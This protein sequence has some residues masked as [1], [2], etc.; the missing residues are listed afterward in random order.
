MKTTPWF[1]AVACLSALGVAH[2]QDA[3]APA[4][5]PRDSEPV[6]KRTV[7]EDKGSRIEELRVRGQTQSITVTPKVGT[8]KSYEIITS[9]GSRDTTDSASATRG[10]AGKRVWHVMSF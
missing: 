9:D 1:I 6:V 7:I 4:S 8:K 10:A 5:S 2:A 3:T